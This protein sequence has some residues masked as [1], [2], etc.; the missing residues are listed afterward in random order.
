M[1]RLLIRTVLVA[2]AF[3]LLALLI[4]LTPPGQSRPCGCQHSQVSQ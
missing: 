3:G 2:I 1:K 4:G